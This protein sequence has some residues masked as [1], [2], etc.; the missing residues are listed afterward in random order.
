MQGIVS[1]ED[2]E[3]FES[4]VIVSGDCRVWQ[5]DT[6]TFRW[7]HESVTPARFAWFME[8][9]KFPLRRLKRL[10]D[11]VRCVSPTHHI[12]SMQRIRKVA[13]RAFV[14]IPATAIPWALTAPFQTAFSQYV[15][16]PD[17]DEDC[18]PWIG[19]VRYSRSMAKAQ[20]IWMRFPPGQTRVEQAYEP[21]SISWGL[22][23]DRRDVPALQNLCGSPMCVN[24]THYQPLK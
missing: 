12:E 20:P 10:C 22:R 6:T 4:K 11:T 23:N 21:R 17:A 24:P 7:W 3:R 18:W 15:K 5:P 8:H 2:R 16:R 9:G 13:T 19:E 1:K 14:Q